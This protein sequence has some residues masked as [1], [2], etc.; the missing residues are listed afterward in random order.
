[1][2]LVPPVIEDVLAQAGMTAGQLD[3]LIVPVPSPALARGVAK[4]VGVP[5]GAI[6][7]VLQDR[8]GHC[9]SAHPL[10]MLVH[11]LEQLDPGKSVLVTGWG[12]GCDAILLRT[13]DRIRSTRPARGLR[14]SMQR[15]REE[16]NYARYLAFNRLIEIDKGLRAE[17]DKQTALS[18]LYRNRRMILGFVGGRC[19]TCGTAQ[20]PRSQICVNPNCHAVGTQEGYR[21]A[22]RNAFIQS[23][24]ADNLTYTP[25]P[26]QHFGMVVFR[27]GGRLM[28][29]FTDVDPGELRTEM[30]VRLVFRIKDFDERRGFPRYFWKA[31][32]DQPIEKEV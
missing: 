30:G 13:T 19:T 4:A 5:D 15:R 7:D 17:V 2:K 3:R 18:A 29:D 32:P 9:G 23:W 16:T 26:P 25:D 24:T 6:C 31:T 1:M 27:E 28:M 20:F 21:F 12:Q 22:D 11:E 14:G 10:L 8:L